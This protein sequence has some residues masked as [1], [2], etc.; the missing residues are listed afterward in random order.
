MEN[1]YFIMTTL[2]L[3]LGL[4]SLVYLI[5]IFHK[6]YKIL[7][8]VDE[9]VVQNTSNINELMTLA[10]NAVKAY[11]NVAEKVNAILFKLSAS[12]SKLHQSIFGGILGSLGNLSSFTK[13]TDFTLTYF[14]LLKELLHIG[15]KFTK[16]STS[17]T[18][19]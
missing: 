7:H 10:P 2:L 16:K 11:T 12:G 4:V 8:Q 9:I 14:R 19:I 1:F 17:K 5:F 13:A 18:A 15:K 3:L 6:L